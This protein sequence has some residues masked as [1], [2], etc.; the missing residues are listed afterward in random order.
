M[1]TTLDRTPV[2]PA[3]PAGSSRRAVKALLAGGAALALLVGGGTMAALSDFAVLPGNRVGVGTLELQVGNSRAQ[4]SSYVARMDQLALLPGQSTDWVQLV[5]VNGTVPLSTLSASVVDLTGAEN[6]C[7]GGER[8]VDANCAT[9]TR[10]DLL[11]AATIRVSAIPAA[12]NGSCQLDTSGVPWSRAGEGRLLAVG[13]PTAV[14]ANRTDWTPVALAA[15][16][17]QATTFSS[18]VGT[19]PTVATFRP[20]DRVCVSARVSVPDTA[21]DQD[22]LLQGDTATFGVRLDL[23]QATQP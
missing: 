16:P 23:V 15:A 12:T 14:N 3:T 4:G 5:T 13:S 1:S 18:Y 17:S 8:V 11:D 7:S 21:S 6:G 10:G 22:N 20:G 19:T 2:T 9:D